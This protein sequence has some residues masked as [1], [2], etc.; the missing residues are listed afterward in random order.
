MN[1][2]D[3]SP[4]RFWQVWAIWH[5]PKI[6]SYSAWEKVQLIVDWWGRIF[7]LSPCAFRR[8]LIR[9]LEYEIP[10]KILDECC[11]LLGIDKCRWMDGVLTDAIRA[12]MVQHESDSNQ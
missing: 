11:E 3:N 9:R 1:N 12:L 4:R 10:A 7:P 2:L 5:D 6:E 8:R